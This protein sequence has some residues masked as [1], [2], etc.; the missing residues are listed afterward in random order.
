MSR[1]RGPW[2]GGGRALGA[3]GRTIGRKWRSDPQAGLAGF[4]PAM[5]NGEDFA[6]EGS[7][8]TFV[9]RTRN[10]ARGYSGF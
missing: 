6:S 3:P 10:A 2:R 4:H 9:V 8:W 7:Q 5:E 1:H